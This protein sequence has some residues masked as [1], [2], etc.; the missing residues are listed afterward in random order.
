MKLIQD[1]SRDGIPCR[2]SFVGNQKKKRREIPPLFHLEKLIQPT[3]CFRVL[4]FP[5]PPVDD[6]GYIVYG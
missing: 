1:D 6:H 5:S 3:G 4:F 2:Q